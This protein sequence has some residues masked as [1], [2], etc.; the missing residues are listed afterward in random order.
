MI[1]RGLDDIGY[2]TDPKDWVDWEFKVKTPGKFEITAII[3]APASGMFGLSV[4]GKTLRCAA[5]MP[6]SYFD[7]QP[8]KPRVVEIPAAGKAKFAVRRVADKGQPMN[9]KSIQ[10]KPVASK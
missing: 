8:V 10:L 5:P 9:L 3:A 1:P 6:T 2:W 7:F 4:A